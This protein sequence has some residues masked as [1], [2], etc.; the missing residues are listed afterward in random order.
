MKIGD[1]VKVMIKDSYFLTMGFRERYG[2]IYDINNHLITVQF[3]NYKE[4]FRKA[5]LLA[6]GWVDMELKQ[7]KEWIKVDKKVMN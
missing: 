1:K 2:K 3:K 7:G 6:K 4:S 5:D